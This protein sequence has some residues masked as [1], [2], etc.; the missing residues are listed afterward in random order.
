[1][2]NTQSQKVLTQKDLIN[3]FLRG[4]KSSQK[5]GVEYE[6][7]GIMPKTFK[8]VPFE[9][10]EHLLEKLSEFEDYSRVFNNFYQ[11]INGIPECIFAK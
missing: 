9:I 2:L 5:I 10:T 4:V 7:I 11:K 6:K 1:M 3:Y 8:A